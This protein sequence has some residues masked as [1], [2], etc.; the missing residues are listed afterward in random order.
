LEKLAEEPDI[1]D[2]AVEKSRGK[3]FT[4]AATAMQQNYRMHVAVAW[5]DD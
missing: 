1:A 2:L 3:V 5:F 4:V